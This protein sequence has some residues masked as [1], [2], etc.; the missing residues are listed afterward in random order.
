MRGIQHEEDRNYNVTTIL[1]LSFIVL[2]L[3][4]I[5]WGYH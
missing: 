5:V 3:V 2:L 1:T 4:E